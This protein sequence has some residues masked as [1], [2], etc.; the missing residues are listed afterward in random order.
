MPGISDVVSRSY[1]ALVGESAMHRWR[2]PCIKFG[3]AAR[4]VVFDVFLRVRI[5]TPSGPAALEDGGFAHDCIVGF[6]AV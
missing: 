6:F 2:T 1:G 5:V 4:T 3:E